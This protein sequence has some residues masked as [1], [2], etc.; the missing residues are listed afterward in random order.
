MIRAHLALFLVNVLY[1]ASHILA[2]GVMPNYL[3]PS[4]FVLLRAIGATA[5]FWLVKLLFIRERI[6]KKDLLR[7]AACGLFGVAVNQLFFLHGLN[8]SSSINSGIIMTINPIMVV[9]ISFFVLKEVVGPRKILGILVGA[10]GGVMLTLSSGST[11]GDSVLGDLFLFINALSYAI[12]LVITKP[13][14]ARYK[15]LTVITWT[16]TFGALYVLLFPP[17]IPGLMQTN[18]ELI[19]AEVWWKIA[20]VVVIVT[21][22]SYLLTIYGLKFLTPSI[23]S[24]YIYLQPVMV[25]LFAFAFWK[26]GI[27]EDYTGSITWLK[28]I[29]MLLIFIGVFLTGSSANRF[30]RKLYSS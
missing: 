18:F 1:G 26:M 21:F 23:S 17:T 7:L 5:L 30:S 28:V 12:Y 16:F 19:P 2:K 15:P 20:Y 10:I 22:L 8:L 9:I 3:N 11:A 6:A 4:V 24:V 13:L 29:Y 25:M 14:M 27:S